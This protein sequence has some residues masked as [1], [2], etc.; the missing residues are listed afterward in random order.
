[1][2][3][4]VAIVRIESPH[5]RWLRLWL[6]LFLLWIPLILLSPLILL[7]TLVVWLTG[8]TNPWRTMGALWAIASNLSG[9]DVRVC[10]QGNRVTVRIV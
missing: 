2:T 6:P 10:R 9:T 7:L 4:N 1:M 3:P 5:W 8:R